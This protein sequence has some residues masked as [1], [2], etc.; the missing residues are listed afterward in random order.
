MATDQL[1]RAHLLVDDMVFKEA[2]RDG[3]MRAGYIQLS[4]LHANFAALVENVAAL[5]KTRQEMRETDRKLKELG[6]RPVDLDRIRR[7]IEVSKHI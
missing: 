5:S 4:K 2:K 3:T 1:A 7:D 6:E